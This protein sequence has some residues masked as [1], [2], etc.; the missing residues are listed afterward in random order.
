VITLLADANVVGHV[1]RMASR[2]QVQPWL[3]FR[4]HL[5]L[6]WMTLVDVG[7]RLD[8]P[9]T[10]VWQVCQEQ[11]LVLVTNNRNYDSLD[12]LESAIRGHGNETSLPVITLADA[13]RIL[14]DND[15]LDAVI[16][17]LLQYLLELD[18]LRGTGRLYVP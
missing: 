18:A 9:D 14:V 10:E 5:D 3:D 8:S 7:L 17:S 15:Y 12:S 11:G 13:D 6:R 16:E 4:D 1:A 2:M